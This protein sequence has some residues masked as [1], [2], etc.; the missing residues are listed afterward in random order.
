MVIA[1]VAT[2]TLAPSL[3][4]K[5]GALATTIT[6]WVLPRHVPGGDECGSGPH[7]RPH[8]AVVPKC[9]GGGRVA[10]AVAL[11]PGL[12]ERRRHRGRRRCLHRAVVRV[13]RRSRRGHR[14]DP[15]PGAGALSVHVGLNLVFLVPGESGGMEVYARELIPPLS[16]VDVVRPR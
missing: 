15:A 3:G 14:C 4:A 6:E 10:A 1:A 8:F 13:A 5:G 2:I 12:P 9:G 16:S 11:L 7:L